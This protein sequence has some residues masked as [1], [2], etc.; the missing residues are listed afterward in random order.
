MTLEYTFS[1]PTKHLKN[2]KKQSLF[3]DAVLNLPV[4]VLIIISGGGRLAHHIHTD[5]SNFRNMAAANWQ[6][7]DKP[8]KRPSGG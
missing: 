4:K 3:A 8:L 7:F 1:A 6:T 5:V 2:R